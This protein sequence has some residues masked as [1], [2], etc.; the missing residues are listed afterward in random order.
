MSVEKS[1]TALRTIGEVAESLD[2]AAHVLRFWE[3][4]FKQINPQKRRGRRYYRPEDVQVVTKIKDLLYNHGYTIKGV[5]K[6]LDQNPVTAKAENQQEQ[7]VAD[8]NASVISWEESNPN[9]QVRVDAIAKANVAAL[10]QIR[11]NLCILRD[12]LNRAA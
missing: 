7:I 8:N 2:L 1:P 3:S 5:K 10:K 6:Y 9:K 4:K 11:E 12:R